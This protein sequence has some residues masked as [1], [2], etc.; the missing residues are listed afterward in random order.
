M[1]TMVL[2][3]KVQNRVR[4]TA[5]ARHAG[6]TVAR[7]AVKLRPLRGAVHTLSPAEATWTSLPLNM[8]NL[9]LSTGGTKAGLLYRS[10]EKGTGWLIASEPGDPGGVPGGGAYPPEAVY[11]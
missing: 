9:V 7:R 11:I 8:M 3:K 1:Y 2:A 6:H 10:M 4:A 5:P